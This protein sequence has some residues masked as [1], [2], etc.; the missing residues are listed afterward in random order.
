MQRLLF[1]CAVVLLLLDASLLSATRAL[2]VKEGA[3]CG[4]IV[5]L[6][7]DRGLYCEYPAGRCDV[8]DLSGR[9][10]KRPQ[11]CNER[12]LPVCSCGGKEYA[13]DCRRQIAGAQKDRDGPCTKAQ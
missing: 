7:C 2:A 11:V 13:N 10:E 6:P 8:M 9:C 1:S 3:V 4:G 5:R 12:F